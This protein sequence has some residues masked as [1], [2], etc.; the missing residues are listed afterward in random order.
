MGVDL[1]GSLIESDKPVENS[2]GFARDD[3]SYS[4]NCNLTVPNINLRLPSF[5]DQG[6]YRL[7]NMENSGLS[8]LESLASIKRVSNHNIELVFVEIAVF[9]ILPPDPLCLAV[10]VC[11]L[12]KFSPAFSIL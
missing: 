4:K 12:E 5:F 2:E 1:L 9:A 6:K 11:G 8:P 3:S 10:N 7:S